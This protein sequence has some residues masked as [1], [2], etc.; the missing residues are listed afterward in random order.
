MYIAS[1]PVFCERTNH[2]EV[3][4]HFIR[5][6]IAEKTIETVHVAL[7]NQSDEI[8]MKSLGGSWVNDICNKLG[9]YDIY[10]QA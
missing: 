10:A 7:E 3:D 4:C 9:D 2:I 6:K 1:N 5:K 8:F